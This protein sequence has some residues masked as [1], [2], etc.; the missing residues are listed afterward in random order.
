MI[1]PYRPQD[2]EAIAALER[3]AFER[4]WT[5]D[6]LRSSLDAEEALARVAVESLRDAPADRAGAGRIHGYILF[7]PL[8]GAAEAELLRIAVAP[9]QRRRGLGLRL[10]HRGL[11]ALDDTVAECHLE[12]AASN[13]AALALYRRQGFV[14]VGRRR[15]YYRAIATA[16]RDDALL[17]RRRRPPN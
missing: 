11:A 12:V 9:D 6:A 13:S 16:E 14:E 10:L 7:R 4:P 5:I 3:E 1:R 15:G 17:L 2:L 8:P